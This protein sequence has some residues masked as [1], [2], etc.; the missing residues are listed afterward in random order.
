GELLKGYTFD[1]YYTSALQRAQRT[2]DL[3]LDSMGIT[4]LTIVRNKALNER[5]YGDL[6][7][8]NKA[9]TAKEFGEE[10]VHIWRRSYD[11]PP[12]GNGES[13][14]DTAARTLPYFREHILPALKAGKNILVVAHGNSLRSIVMEIEQL[15]KEEVLQLNLGTGVPYV[16]EVDESGAI[17]NKK[18]LGADED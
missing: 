9:E 1:G 5:H 7:G 17:T 16:Y 18:T 10:Q 15:T 14:K 8:K 3:V 13:L 2:L 12:P 11:V 6:Q 4:D